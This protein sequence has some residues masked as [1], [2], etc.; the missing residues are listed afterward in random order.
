M[1]AQKMFLNIFCAGGEFPA[2]MLL[3][4]LENG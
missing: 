3:P 4:V 1:V 2:A